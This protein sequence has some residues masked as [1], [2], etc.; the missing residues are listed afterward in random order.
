MS[1]KY[2]VAIP[3][4]NEEGYVA[5]VLE[6]TRRY[7]DNILVI[8]DGSSDSTPEQLSRFSGIHVIRHE[9]NQGYGQ[10]LIDAFGFA[11]EQGYDWLITMDC[12]EQHEPAAIPAFVAAMERDAADVIS[13]S[14][15]LRSHPGDDRP[16]ADRRSINLK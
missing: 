9:R 8:D 5:A 10:S 15:Y 7:A 12:D 13:G 3:V 6:R 16:P 14:R 2:L 1:N 11:A 4:F